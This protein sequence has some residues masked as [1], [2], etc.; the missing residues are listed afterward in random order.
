MNIL[1][2]G[3][4][5]GGHIYPCISLYNYLKA[6]NNI[7]LIIF[8][9]IDEKIYKLNNIKYIFIDN[10]L[11]SYKKLKKIKEIFNT[12][13][14]EKSITFGGK[15]SLYINIISKLMKVDNYIFEQNAIM[16]K[17]NKMNY[18]I[19]NKVFSNFKLNLKKEIQVG[20]PNSFQI[21]SN[22]KLKYFNNK[23]AVILITLGS[24]GSQTVNKVIEKFIKEND[25]YNF[26]YILGN[27]VKSNI[28]NSS[29]IKVFQYYN[30][31]SELISY[32]DIIV[33]RA[34]ASTI[35]ELIALNKP[36]ILIP[37]PYVVN[38]HQEKN[39][40]ILLKNNACLVIKENELNTSILKQDIAK[41]TCNIELYNKLKS[42]LSKMFLGNNFKLIEEVILNDNT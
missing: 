24:L 22:S 20:N 14:I 27:N 25:E 6:D 19:C 31:L 13:K 39:A 21:K 35:S 29:N 2:S 18:L 1:M 36:S 42:N 34:G 32:A 37:S 11:S 16:G 4:G 3:S 12:Y 26:I 33:S 28:Q 9:K 41:L 5:S 15:N 23:K 7:V 38:N 10:D 30:P 17:A 8:K 40:N